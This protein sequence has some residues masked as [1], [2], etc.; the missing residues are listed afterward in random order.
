MTL[1]AVLHTRSFYC[2]T[3]HIRCMFLYIHSTSAYNVFRKARFAIAITDVL[4]KIARTRKFKVLL[5]VKTEIWPVNHLAL[6]LSL[7]SVHSLL[8]HT[9][10]PSISTQ[11]HLK[12]YS[13][14]A[15]FFFF[16]FSIVT[17]SPI[18]YILTIVRPF[19][20]FMIFCVSHL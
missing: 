3:H 5:G 7:S 19:I 12:Y 15:A 20:V 8:T 14:L 16:K 17:L 13:N 4:F 1:S 2:A 9:H 11:Y 10:T 6:F 18:L